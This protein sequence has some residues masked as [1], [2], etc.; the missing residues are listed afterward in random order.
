MQQQETLIESV[1][2]YENLTPG[3]Y[4]S[5]HEDEDIEQQPLLA[6]GEYLMGPPE[7]GVVLTVNADHY[8]SNNV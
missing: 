1:H 2:M 6:R 5:D 7:Q 3:A 8:E 4:D